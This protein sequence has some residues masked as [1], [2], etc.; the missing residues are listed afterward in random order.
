MMSVFYLLLS[1]MH[2]VSTMKR[3]IRSSEVH[4]LVTTGPDSKARV[5]FC[6]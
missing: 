2:T 6:C 4:V 5:F 3:L 1:L